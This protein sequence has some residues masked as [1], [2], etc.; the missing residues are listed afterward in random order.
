M[1]SLLTKSISK[2]NRFKPLF[3]RYLLRK[4][5]SGQLI[6]VQVAKRK[7]ENDFVI[8]VTEKIQ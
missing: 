4:N 3:E 2:I 1:E 8:A 5:W 7:R 6:S